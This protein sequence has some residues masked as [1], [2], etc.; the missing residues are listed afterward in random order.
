MTAR[1][2]CAAL[3]LTVLIC[4]RPAPAASPTKTTPDAYV[5]TAVTGQSWLKRLN[6][7][8]Q[9]SAMGQSGHV[10]AS[11]ATPPWGESSSPESLQKP[12]TLTGADLYRINCQ[13]C[14]NVEG[15][16]TPPEIRSLLDAVRATSPAAI[17]A[18]MAKRGL[19]LD[20]E[21]VGQMTS[22]ADTAL[23]ERLSKGGE[24]MP[25]FSHLAG[26]EIDALLDYLKVLADVP[27]SGKRPVS[28]IEPATRVG[29]HLVKGTCFVCHDATGPGRDA[30]ATTPGLIPSLASF[31]EQNPLASVVHKVRHG[32][33]SPGS[34]GLR[35]EMPVFSYLTE[36]EIKAAYFYLA[37]YPPQP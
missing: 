17:R 11:A 13:S 6:L 10:G 29:E 12:F 3:V 20:A 2:R 7:T 26:A 14:H 8:R 24:K 19:T 31:L 9:L 22:Q 21:T 35:G 16:G 27:R 37:A 33:P 30:I 18:Q 28:V 4:P 36:E 5:V 34:M 15:I 32:A 25:P 1:W 23:R